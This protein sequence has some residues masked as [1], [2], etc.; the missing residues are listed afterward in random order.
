[1]RLSWLRWP[2]ISVL[3]L[4]ALT[5]LLLVHHMEVPEEDYMSKVRRFRT[6]RSLTAIPIG[7]PLPAGSVA[8]DSQNL[9]SPPRLPFPSQANQ[10]QVPQENPILA[11][12][13]SGTGGLQPV[14]V[15][16]AGGSAAAPSP[17]G[18]SSRRGVAGVRCTSKT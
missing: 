17:G 1:M 7:T 10:P 6:Q 12:V 3:A 9:N 16:G 14:N 8:P 4:L 5:P 13:A 18:C 11:P 2:I 15:E